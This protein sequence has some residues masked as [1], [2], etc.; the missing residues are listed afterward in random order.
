MGTDQIYTGNFDEM[1]RSARQKLSGRTPGDLAAACGFSYDAAEEA[2]SFTSL[3]TD[4]K[5]S[6]P[7]LVFEPKT[8]VWQELTILQYMDAA[9]GTK[10]TGEDISLK[11]FRVGGMVR[12]SYFDAQCDG[13][14]KRSLGKTDMEEV[15]RA[16]LMLGGTKCSGI[17]DLNMDFMFMPHFRFKMCLWPADDE[18]PAQCRMLCDSSAE[19]YLNV[20]AAGLMAVRLLEMLEEKLN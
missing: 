2:F 11:E 17:A 20:E 12:G 7:D 1:I 8:D 19:K 10:M 9:L 5:V 4:M 18:F 6:W 3:G 14:A 16:G 15:A 13:I